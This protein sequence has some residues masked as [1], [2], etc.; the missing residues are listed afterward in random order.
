VVFAHQDLALDPPF[1][2]LDLVSCRNL[3]IYF[4]TELQAKVLSTFHYALRAN[5]LLF[6]GRSENI[7][8]Q[9]HLFEPLDIKA[10]IFRPKGGAAHDD[11]AKTLRGHLG[12][13]AGKQAVEPRESVN[14]VFNQLAFR[15]YVP[16]LVLLDASLYVIHTLGDLSAYVQLADGTPRLEFPNMLGQDLRMELLT[17]VHRAR[18]KRKQAKGRQRRVVPGRAGLIRLSVSPYHPYEPVEMF[19]VSFEP[20]AAPRRAAGQSSSPDTDAKVLEEE[21]IATRKHLQ[22]VIQELETSNEEMQAL[23]EE[24]QASNEELATVN[25][26]LVV[27]SAELAALN[28]DFESVQNGVDFP[29][30]VLDTRLQVTRFNRA[31]EQVVR[32]TAMCHHRSLKSLRLPSAFAE[33]PAEA[34]QVLHDGEIIHRTLQTE[35]ADYRLQITPY[36]D[37]AGQPRGVVIGLADQTETARAERQAREL[38]RRLLDVMNH[39]P[40]MFAVKDQA[41]CYQFANQPFLNFFG[42]THEQILGRSDHQVFS[43]ELAER[44]QAKDLEVLR[45]RQRRRGPCRRQPALS[46][47]DPFSAHGRRRQAHCDQLRDTGYHAAARGRRGSAPRRQRFQVRRRRHLCHRWRGNNPFGQ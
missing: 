42:L 21:L 4:A 29:L 5:G 39:T 27:K 20:Q 35:D 10:R 32:L 43:R 13:V 36:A 46:A 14:S 38:Q 16:P 15:A 37:H 23:N 18:T 47:R 33:L 44:Q 9:D 41:C 11:V 26:E 6:L 24:V 3:L 1:L 25:Q 34:E 22:T 45:R 30:V 12:A 19:L 2:R 17:L 7:S 8:Q 28:A 31:A 40:S